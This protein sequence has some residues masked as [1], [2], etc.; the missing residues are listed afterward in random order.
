M[1][2]IEY[3]ALP[4]K[5]KQEAGKESIFDEVR[6]QWVRLTPEEWVRQN[7]I[8]YL[9]QVKK[10]PTAIMAVEKEIMLGELR[11]R[12]DIVIYREH[13]PWM[14]VEC[15]EMDVVLNDA[16]A[17]QVFRYNMALNV[18][19]LVVTNGNYTF[20]MET[21]TRKGLEALPEFA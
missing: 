4:F 15:K 14:I 10:Y 16:V 11:K 17:A 19:Y 7:F 21:A 3:P 1:V 13:K 6:K 5:M 8:Q 20:A 2:K 9:V 18:Q 12:C